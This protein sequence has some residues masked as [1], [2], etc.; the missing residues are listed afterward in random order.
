[1]TGPVTAVRAAARA[2]ALLVAIALVALATT[3]CDGSTSRGTGRISSGVLLVYT[4]QPLIGPQRAS[5]RAV[6]EGEQMALAADGGR[7]GRYTVR[8]RPLDDATRSSHGWDP[9][10]TTANATLAARDARTIGYLGD[11]NSG[12][13]AVSLPI[14]NRADIPQISPLST[15]VGLTRSG[16]EASPGEPEK[17]LPTMRRTFARVVPNDTVQSAVQVALQQ[18]AGCR[19]VYVLFDDEV[20]G[21]DAA[22]SFDAAADRAHLTVVGEDQIDADAKSYASLGAKLAK[23]GPDCVLVSALMQDHAVAV[24][25]AV[26]RA[27]PRAELF[28]TSPLAQPAFVD[29]RRGGVALTVDPRLTI[30]APALPAADL[31]P[32]GRRLLARFHHRYGAGG[33]DGIFGDEA[34]SL[35]LDAIR[36][37]SDGGTRDVTRSRVLRAIFATRDRSSVLGAYSIDRAGDTSLRRFGVYHAVDGRLVFVTAMR[38]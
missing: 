36:R 33:M 22:D 21:R 5:G 2:A 18:Q 16:P 37:A 17:Y 6:L 7:V 28:I 31:P 27:L 23:A 38:G 32:S 13:T 34:M 10:Q 3:G 8:L 25:D 35:L 14:L 20:D 26:A 29:P 12:A 9:G 4:G 19:R 11:L 1:V 30:T 24:T 15:A